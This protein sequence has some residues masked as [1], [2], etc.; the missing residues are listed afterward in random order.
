M[1]EHYNIQPNFDYCLIGG[2]TGECDYSKNSH[3][4]EEM[5]AETILILKRVKSM[6][7]CKL[8]FIPGN[9]DNQDFFHG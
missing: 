1:L 6:L 4:E 7:G 3:D 9:H 8:L 2:D 5:L